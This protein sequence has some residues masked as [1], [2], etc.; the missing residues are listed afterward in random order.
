[1]G[2][3]PEVEFR[4]ELEVFGNEIEEAIQCFYAEQT[5]HNCARKDESVYHALNRNAMFWNLTCRALQANAIIVLGRIFDRHSQA[6]TLNRLFELATQ[7]PSIFSKEALE[8]RKRPQ[9][10]EYTAEF[11]RTAYVPKKCDFKRLQS[12]ADKHRAIYNRCYADLRN[13]FFAHRE[14]IDSTATFANAEVRVLGQLLVFLRQ[15]H[16]ALW[17]LLMNGRKPVLRP[18]R[19]SGRRILNSPRHRNQDAQEW[20]T[21]EVES[22]LRHVTDSYARTR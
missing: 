12:F 11:V 13:K 22:F 14:R 20:A 18:A 1:M 2:N 15:L 9:A 21:R 10:G 19:H 8:R 16:D 17:Q 5:I 7:N 6:H 4:R 3:D